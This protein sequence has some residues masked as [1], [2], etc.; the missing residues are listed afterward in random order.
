MGTITRSHTF[1]AGEKPTDDQWNVD[2][3]QT[4]T[5]INGNLDESNVDYSSSDGIVTLQQTQTITGTKTFD[6]A[7]T[8][9]TSILPDSAGGADM[10]S[11]TQEWGDVYVADDKFIKFGSDQNVFVGYDETTTDSLKFAA[12][13]GAGL[14]ITL[15]A[16]EGDDA[17]DEWKLNVA[18]GGTLTLGNDIASAGTY[19]TGLTITPNSTTAAWL[20][21]FE[22]D[23][24]VGGDTLSFNG[25]ATIDTSG[26]NALSLD[27]GS[28]T[29][30]LDGGTIESDA[31]TLSFDAAT[32]IDTSGNNALSLDAGS[33]VLTL[34]G[35]TIESDASTFSFDGAAT[36][37]TSGNNA[38]SLDAGSAVLT[39]DGGTLESDASTF[40]FDAAATID[41]SG[42][43]ALS[44]D[45][46][47]AV[48]TLDGGTIE[49]DASTLSF[50]AAATIDTSGNNNL[51]LNA[52]TGTIVATAGDVTVF[53]DN[54]NADVSMSIGTSATEALVVQA[55]NGSS[56]KTLEEL[57]F[58][59][60]T[61]SGTANHGKITFYIDE[62]EIGTIDDGGIDLASGMTFAINGSDL[63][64]S[65]GDFSGPGSSTDNAVV[66]FDGTGGKTAQNSGVAIDDSN[67][68]SG[69]GTLATTGDV[70]IFDDAN[71]ADTSLSIGTSATEAL[72][73]QALNGGSNKTLEELRFT[74]KTASGTGDHGKMSFYVDEAEIATIDDG[75]IDLASGLSFTVAGS[76][77]GGADVGT[78]NT[79]TADQTFNDNVKVTL[80]TGGD[81]DIFY[82]A[83]DLI[84]NPA[85]AG[86]G[87]VKI[88]TTRQIMA[89]FT[90]T[91]VNPFI[92]ITGASE[93]VD[94]GGGIAFTTDAGS[95]VGNTGTH[96]YIQGI[97]TQAHAS[98]L[99]GDLRF[100]TNGGDSLAERM[101]I[102]SGGGLTF[103]GDTAAANALDDY[104]EGTWTPAWRFGGAS[105]TS[106]AIGDT[107]AWYTKIG[108]DVTVY[109]Y[110]NMANAVSGSGIMVMTG[111][112]Y[113]IKNTTNAGTSAIPW[114][115]K[116]SY[117]DAPSV[118]AYPNNTYL[119]FESLT[120][121]T[122]GSGVNI[123]EGNC[124]QYSQLRFQITYRC[125]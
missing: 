40:S 79:W 114:T 25:A 55:L 11:A 1:V 3:D 87:H 39:L 120:D 51:T 98:A 46:G 7:T 18:D 38:L 83:T 103:N 16:D 95:L 101:R 30:T 82:D 121:S 36:I 97:V 50:D 112:P 61:A 15:M 21:D 4:F 123:T 26:N 57:R 125:E 109:F 110:G 29:L 118:M 37:D 47:S 94:D 42:N 14:A 54:N 22:G 69:V 31:T 96:A 100:F 9:N 108:G 86:T 115:N 12:T 72:V 44:L 88:D 34:D 52:G 8:F 81:A 60:K 91:T 43:N 2:I 113:T 73:V 58:T 84:I 89:E 62:A 70:T 111:L 66:R 117:A 35:G 32:T 45:A 76:A 53:D 75:G 99:K 102:L 41:T 68:V 104:E 116:I 74:T 65:A 23:I 28:A 49:S 78:A 59:T 19:V 24:D 64:S 92:T 77:V 56:N 93:A 85:V 17:G 122:S 90:S 119:S 10:G 33:A 67:N 107:H 6:A 27:A 105:G 48:L 63:P 20:M 13:E 5:L 71:N 106:Q 80:G 124:A